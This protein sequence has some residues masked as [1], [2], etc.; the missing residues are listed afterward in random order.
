MPDCAV[1]A[2]MA[3]FVVGTIAVLIALEW[4]KPR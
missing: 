2:S 3:L 1:W 4:A